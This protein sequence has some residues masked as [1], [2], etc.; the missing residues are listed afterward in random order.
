MFV[1]GLEVLSEVFVSGVRVGGEEDGEEEGGNG[2]GKE[3]GD[4]QKGLAP[5]EGEGEGIERKKPIANGNQQNE[6]PT[7]AEV[8]SEVEGTQQKPQQAPVNGNMSVP[9]INVNEQS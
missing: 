6:Q 7:P 8:K 2:K 4:G 5:L 3:G 1:A 9:T